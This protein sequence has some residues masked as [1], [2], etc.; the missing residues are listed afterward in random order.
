M[1]LLKKAKWV[2]HISKKFEYINYISYFKRIILMGLLIWSYYKFFVGN[3]V[4]HYI[5]LLDKI[6]SIMG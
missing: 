3:E 1:K 2:E 4:K 6:V 5:Y